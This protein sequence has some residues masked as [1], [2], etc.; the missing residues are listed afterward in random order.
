MDDTSHSR[1][2]FLRH[3]SLRSLALAGAAGGLSGFTGFSESSQTAGGQRTAPLTPD[4]SLA[5]LK[6]G[7]RD[8]LAGKIRTASTDKERR[9]QLA[10]NQTPFAVLVGCSDS[11]VPRCR[12]GCRHCAR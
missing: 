6:Q 8:F 4:E 10:R 5:K 3:A 7:N 2:D 9:L 12:P 11:R 1:R